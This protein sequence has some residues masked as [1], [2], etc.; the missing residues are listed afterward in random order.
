MQK[1]FGLQGSILSS[2]ASFG[3][4]SYNFKAIKLNIKNTDEVFNIP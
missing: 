4:M 2:F 3:E 1:F